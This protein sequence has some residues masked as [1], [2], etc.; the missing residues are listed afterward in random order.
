VLDSFRSE[1]E[2]ASRLHTFYERVISLLSGE[3]ERAG[4]R[5]PVGI[6]AFVYRTAEG[7]RRLKPIVEI[8]PRYTMGRL[9]L[10]L[11]KQVCP[12]SRGSFRI[13]SR[14]MARAEGFGEWTGY[15]RALTEGCP[16]R[17]EG[18]P[19][20]RI[21]EGTLCLNDPM[22]AQGYLAVFQVGR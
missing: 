9:T 15:A 4:H 16:L 8:N 19:V 17:L 18:A 3:L 20:A 11:M 22:A 13:V 5:G 10:E 7:G 21:R 12:G 6:D 14:A 1:R 2:G